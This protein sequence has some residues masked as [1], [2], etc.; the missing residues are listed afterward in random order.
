MRKVFFLLCIP[1]LIFSQNKFVYDLNYTILDNG[2]SINSAIKISKPVS[3]LDIYLAKPYVADIRLQENHLKF[4]QKETSNKYK[5]NIAANAN[6]EVNDFTLSYSLIKEKN[7]T[8]ANRNFYY[9][10]D[11]FYLL[12]DLNYLPIIEKQNKDFIYRTTVQHNKR[13]TYVDNEFQ[14]KQNEPP[15]I[16]LGN[17]NI[18]RQNKIQS[19][20]PVNINYNKERLLSICKEIELSYKYFSRVF[21]IPTKAQNTFKLF[22]LKRT[23]GHGLPSGLILNQEYLLG[24]E[25][26]ISK[27]L[28]SLIAHEVSHYWWGTNAKIHSSIGEGLAEYSAI[29]YMEDVENYD[30]KKTFLKK[31][32]QLDLLQSEKVK[33]DT[34]TPYNTD[35]SLYRSISYDRL[36]IVFRELSYK[37]GK[38][39]FLSR[40]KSLFEKYQDQ[41]KE[42][43][44]DDFLNY[45]K[46]I[47]LYQELRNEN[48]REWP[49]F[50]IKNV[51]NNKITFAVENLT[52]DKRLPIQIISDQE[53]VYSDVIEFNANNLEISK[54]YNYNIKEIILDP[55]FNFNQKTSI[56]DVY[57]KSPLNTSSSKYGEVFEKKFYDFSNMLIEYLFYK[58][59]SI[60][61]INIKNQELLD[62]ITSSTRKIKVKGFLLFVDQKKDKMKIFIDFESTNKQNN[63]GYIS[64]SYIEKNGKIYLSSFDKIKL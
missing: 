13:Y 46:D 25:E 45:F 11:Q 10:K 36:P 34:I 30:V 28:K 62:K 37:I 33:I 24:T 2:I 42:I 31:N 6:K 53:K 40:L 39:N 9:D 14:N 18:S 50:Y 64:L 44:Y 61:T 47:N 55:D 17:F 23:G 19:F 8:V 27:G 20:I 48:M 38:E 35:N 49:D 15:Y 41:E 52:V 26:K 59:V 22:F 12:P 29:S 43:S 56:N 57:S 16:I 1:F 21:G 7:D 32:L 60:D 5:I 58:N 54:S 3:I 51:S 63:I 4:E